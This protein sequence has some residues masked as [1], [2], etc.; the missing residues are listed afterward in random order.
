LTISLPGRRLA[1]VLASS[2]SMAAV[3]V[4]ALSPQTMA[5]ARKPACPSSSIAHPK[6][7]VHACAR[8]EHTSKSPHKGNAHARLKANRHHAKHAVVNKRERATKNTTPSPSTRQTAAI[9]DDGSVP[10]RA[11]DGSFS[12]EDDS[13]ATCENGANPST[14]S[15]G[16]TLVCGVD[17]SGDSGSTGVACEDGTAATQASDGSFSCAEDSEP[18]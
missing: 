18:A 1:A 10:V 9:C 14:S 16:S 2:L 5:Q 3:V 6:R 8:S 15:D 17:T 4:L 12:C 7:G 13:E 11:G